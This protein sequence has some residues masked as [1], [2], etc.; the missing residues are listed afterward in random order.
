MSRNAS[1][2]NVG[3]EVDGL[4]VPASWREERR[5]LKEGE[6]EAERERGV[7]GAT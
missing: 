3:G 5:V 2:L 7:L 6:L 4:L 1:F